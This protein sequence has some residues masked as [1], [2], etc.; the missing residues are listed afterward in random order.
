MRTK[1]LWLVTI[2]ALWCSLTVSAQTD[3]T[4]EYIANPSFEGGSYDCDNGTGN[5]NLF[6]P[7]GW[8]VMGE[9]VG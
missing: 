9:T 6:S 5:G 2:A 1:K 7:E 4:A 3:V 8:T